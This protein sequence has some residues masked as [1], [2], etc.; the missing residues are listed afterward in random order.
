M[1]Q[2]L[3]V[4]PSGGKDNAKSLV[5]NCENCMIGVMPFKDPLA[6]KRRKA[7]AKIAQTLKYFYW[8]RKY[9]R[10]GQVD[11]QKLT[12]LFSAIAEVF[13]GRRTGPQPLHK[14]NSDLGQEVRGR[15]LA[16]DGSRQEPCLILLC[17]LNAQHGDCHLVC[18]ESNG[19]EVRRPRSEYWR[20][21]EVQPGGLSK[22]LSTSLRVWLQKSCSGSIHPS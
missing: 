7:S 13:R 11:S 12:T 6:S 3:K 4:E 5:E 2:A 10:C 9:G 14:S 21:G 15:G 19:L 20:S 17:S 1:Q 18:T 16:Q 8:C 22:S